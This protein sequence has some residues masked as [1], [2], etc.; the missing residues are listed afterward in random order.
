MTLQEQADSLI[1]EIQNKLKEAAQLDAREKTLTA[2]DLQLREKM[3]QLG[4]REDKLATDRR[5]LEQEKE[6]LKQGLERLK[7]SEA[8]ELRIDGK[9]RLL[10]DE[11]QTIKQSREKAEREREILQKV[12]DGARTIKEAQ[13]DLT[14]REAA[15]RAAEKAVE[16]RAED[17]KQQELANLREAERL[18]RIAEKLSPG[19]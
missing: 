7:L 10:L 16:T 3:R 9:R 15:H 11:E 17:A 5:E 6:F 14:R 13:E 19:R 12:V 1:V 2:T 18:Q 8:V 4:T